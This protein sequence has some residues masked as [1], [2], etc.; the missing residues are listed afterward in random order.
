[1]TGMPSFGRL[2]LDIKSYALYSSKS[3]G[4]KPKSMPARTAISSIRQTERLELNTRLIPIGI[5]IDKLR[6]GK[7]TS[8]EENGAFHSC[9]S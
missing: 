4:L 5:H 9:L 3:N 7:P 8:I 2:R 1:M 6:L